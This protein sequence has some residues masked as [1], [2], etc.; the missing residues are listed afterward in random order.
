MIAYKSNSSSCYGSKHK[1]TY[2][3]LC[4]SLIT[5]SLFFTFILFTSL[6]IMVLFRLGDN[7]FESI[8]YSSARCSLGC[9]YF[10]YLL[11]KSEFKVDRILIWCLRIGFIAFADVPLGHALVIAGEA[12]IELVA[13]FVGHWDN[14]LLDAYNV[15][16][17]L[18]VQAIL[19]I[20]LDRP[21]SQ[22]FIVYFSHLW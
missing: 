22:L 4:L 20:C 7:E 15:F 1:W 13:Q 18:V 6:S 19:S 5:F 11:Q 10:V 17:Q 12:G 3:T 21:Y 9:W 14:F 8:L 2:W 16:H